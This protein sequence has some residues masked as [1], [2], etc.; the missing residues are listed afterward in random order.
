ML[1]AY[2]LLASLAVM[3]ASLVGVFSVSKHLGAFIE[4]NLSMLVSFSA[5]VFLLIGYEL[6]TETLA[7]A[8]SA[9][10]GVGW[11]ITGALALW[12][13][14]RFAPA[15]HHHHDDSEE[16]GRHSRIDGRRVLL[17]DALHNVGDGIL[18]TAAFAVGTPF[19]FVTAASVFVHEV[20]Q[21][22]SEF[23][24]L[25]QAG[26]GMRRALALNFLV[27]GTILIG[28]L[29]GFFL[30]ETFEALETPLL[31]LAAGA[32]AVVLAH[33]LIPHS[34]RSSKNAARRGAHTL[35]HLLWFLLGAL[36]M[37]GAQSLAAPRRVF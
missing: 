30:L 2:L 24:V 22:V 8:P 13:V 17:S 26:Y 20:V 9:V 15:F 21:E 37:Y 7:H 10:Q 28:A 6:A 25:R 1:L 31:G 16:N 32:L 5:G 4:R 27:S 34:V 3:L 11:I 19:G 35:Q 23:F 12:L 33:D 36:L 29:G 18:L 14:F